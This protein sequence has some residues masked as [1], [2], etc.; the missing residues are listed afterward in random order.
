MHSLKNVQSEKNKKDS[1]TTSLLV[2]YKYLEILEDNEC[3]NESW[4]YFI[5]YDL[6]VTNEL[7]EEFDEC[8]NKTDHFSLVSTE[9]SRDA[10]DFLLSRN[11][12]EPTSY[13]NRYNLKDRYVLTQT[14]LSNFVDNVD[15]ETID[16]LWYK[17]NISFE[18]NNTN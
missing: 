15:A 9:L 18:F 17:G 5:P 8:L 1:T 14:I 7:M 2:E 6:D 16:Q 13:K 12:I 3:E 11:S 4:S 10:V